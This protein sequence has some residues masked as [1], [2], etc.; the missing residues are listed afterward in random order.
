MADTP[1][2]EDSP[3][4]LKR[5]ILWFTFYVFFAGAVYLATSW[6][7]PWFEHA[8]RAPVPRIRVS[9]PA[10]PHES[11]PQRSADLDRG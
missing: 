5:R 7:L 6:M 1:Q 3:K 4:S 10:E 11:H 2:D 9:P 8:R